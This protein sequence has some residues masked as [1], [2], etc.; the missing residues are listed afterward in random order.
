MLGCE[1]WQTGCGK[2]PELSV[3]PSIEVDTTAFL[4]RTKARIYQHSDMTIVTPSEWMAD[5]ARRSPLLNRFAIHCIPHGLDTKMFKP[6]SKSSAR[7]TLGIPLDVKV[8]LFSAFEIFHDRKGSVYL[9]EALQRLVEEGRKDFLLVTVGN[10]RVNLGAKYRFPIHNV[11]LIKDEKV[12]ALSYNA[13]DLYAGPSL[14]EAFGLVYMEAMAC[15]TPVIAFN[16]TAVPEVVRHMQSGY[17][18]RVKDVDDLTHGLRLLLNDDVLREKFS[19][20]C[21]ELVER[22]YTL[23]LQA[24]RYIDLY[25]HVIARRTGERKNHNHSLVVE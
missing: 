23:E 10:D 15:A 16:C 4:W 1:R 2:C 17:L 8:I 7:Q 25:E 3:H 12:M 14:A 22:E 11:G 24:R 21:R 6:I 9:F 5:M 13:A 18:A 19:R 20:Q